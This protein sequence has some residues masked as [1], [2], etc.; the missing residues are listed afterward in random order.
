MKAST[1]KI[2]APQ[3]APVPQH[4]HVDL[5]AAA[6]RS[7]QEAARLGKLAEE[8]GDIKT[9]LLSVREY[10]RG[11]ELLMKV[12]G[13][14]RVDIDLAREPQ[15]IAFRD[16]VLRAI[17]PCAECKRRVVAALAANRYAHQAPLLTTGDE[18]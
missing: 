11:A 16:T 8:T 1:K 17:E 12:Q 9:A 3:H 15:V 2:P 14:A 7:M 13:N 10:S 6:I 4:G 5:P 18:T